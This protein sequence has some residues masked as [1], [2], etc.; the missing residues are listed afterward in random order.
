MNK[1]FD[2]AMLLMNWFEVGILR[3]VLQKNNEFD[4]LPRSLQLKL[5]ILFCQAY[6]SHDTLGKQAKKDIDNY[7]KELLLLEES[8]N[9]KSK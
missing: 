6:L 2:D 8:N 7:Y 5:N 3:G 1:L 9:E 4:K